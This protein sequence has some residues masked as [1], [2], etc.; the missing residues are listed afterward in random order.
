MELGISTAETVSN[1]SNSTS[2]FCEMVVSDDLPNLSRDSLH[3]R[4]RLYESLCELWVPL[5]YCEREMMAI[6]WIGLSILA[7]A[8]G[9]LFLLR[10]RRA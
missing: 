2:N 8:V 7:V 3:R 10:D 4:S 5:D 9:A 6:Q 1:Q